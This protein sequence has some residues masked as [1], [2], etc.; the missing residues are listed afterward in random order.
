MLHILRTSALVIPRERPTVARTNVVRE[1]RYLGT[2]GG[3]GKGPRTARCR[4]VGPAS[5]VL[6]TPR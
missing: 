4:L 2:I 5:K 6:P 1:R 3:R